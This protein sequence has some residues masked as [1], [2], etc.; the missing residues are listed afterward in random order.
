M[1]LGFIPLL[2]LILFMPDLLGLV[3]PFIF[4]VG[5]VTVIRKFVDNNKA[6]QKAKRRNANSNARYGYSAKTS[7]TKNDAD[8][9]SLSQLTKIDKKLETYFKEN[10]YLNIIENVALTTQKGSY[11]TMDE[12]YITYKEEKICKLSE[13]KSA[14]PEIYNKIQSLLLAFSKQKTEVLKEDVKIDAQSVKKEDKL[15]DAQKYIDKIDSLNEAIPNEEITNG[16]YQTSHLL[17]QIDLDKSP[18]KNDKLT[19]LYDYYLPILVNILER[20]DKLDDSPLRDEEFYK[21]ENQLI[22]TI[23]LINEALKTIYSSLHEEDY[24]N[25]NADITTLESLL[26]K[27]GLVDQPFGGVK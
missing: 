12:L 10:V 20:Y 5:M 19:K 26:K 23:V 14:F 22:K 27:D 8:S 21:T 2:F 15:S 24:M 1:G 4:I 9:I 13:I 17:K 3:F 16:L 25:L 11:T 7:Q 6:Q 18:K